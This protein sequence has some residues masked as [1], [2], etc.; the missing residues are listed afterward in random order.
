MSNDEVS[1]ARSSIALISGVDCHSSANQLSI[2]QWYD[3]ILITT[4]SA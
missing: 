4:D 2:G 1:A 3:H